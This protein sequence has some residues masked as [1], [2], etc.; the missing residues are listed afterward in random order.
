MMSQFTEAYASLGLNDESINFYIFCVDESS[1][2][3]MA[4]KARLDATEQVIV[5]TV[6]DL[7]NQ[8]ELRRE[9]EA[10]R[11]EAEAVKAQL[12]QKAEEAESYKKQ[13]N[14]AKAEGQIS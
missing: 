1:E 8:D 4:K 7:N 5:S 11:K 14:M 3:P 2:E 12:R 10:V 9:L 13:L 6:S